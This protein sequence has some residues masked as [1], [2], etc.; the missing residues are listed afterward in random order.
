M[1]YF[2]IFCSPVIMNRRCVVVVSFLLW[3][4]QM[5]EVRL[6]RELHEA[7][8]VFNSFSGLRF[9]PGQ[10]PLFSFALHIGQ[11]VMRSGVLSVDIDRLHVGTSG[12]VSADGEGW[13][14]ARL[15][16]ERLPRVSSPRGCDRQ[17]QRAWLEYERRLEH[18]CK[19][20]PC[21]T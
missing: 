3:V 19:H 2:I 13:H 18:Y 8:S 16:S 12:D 14:G 21:P 15:V 10:R 4:T 20:D 17:L 1:R 6:S 5:Q 11:G 9:E 7:V